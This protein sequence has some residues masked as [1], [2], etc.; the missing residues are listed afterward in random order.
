[1]TSYT[2]GLARLEQATRASLYEAVLS[3]LG[4]TGTI[5][6]IG[7]PKHGLLS[8][9]TFKSVGAEQHVWTP[10]EP[11]ED[12][13]TAVGQK[14]VVPVVTFNGTDEEVDSPNAAYYSRDDT[15]ANPFTVGAWV[16]LA[17]SGNLYSILKK[18]SAGATEEWK[19]EHTTGNDLQF[20]LVDMI[21]N[22]TITRTTDAALTHGAWVH[23][24]ATYDSTGGADA[25]GTSGST[26]DNATLYVDGAIV[27]STAA[28]NAAYVA[29]EADTGLAKLGFGNLSGGGAAR[30]FNGKMAGGPIGPF[31]TQIELTP[32]QVL[33]LYEI[34]RRALYL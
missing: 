31:F 33:R 5:I 24:V 32:D 13:D 2:R 17:G 4:T 15:G 18:G 23:L 29:M 27:A 12:W 21:A 1:M 28:D 34:G 3:I 25:M 20:S 9:A 7:D 22:V 11:L 16:H 6:P 10:S 19:L 26:Q 14:G 30:F 8:A